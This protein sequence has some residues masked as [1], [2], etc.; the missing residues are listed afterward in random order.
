[1]FALQTPVLSLL[2]LITSERKK[3]REKQDYTDPRQ[4]LVVR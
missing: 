2:L 1:M 4:R 3:H